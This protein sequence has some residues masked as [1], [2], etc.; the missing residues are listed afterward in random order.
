MTQYLLS[1]KTCEE[2]YLMKSI[3]HVKINGLII[4]IGTFQKIHISQNY[5]VSQYFKIIPHKYK[6][7]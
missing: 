3:S 2:D 5:I 1:K 4:F 7:E 6:I